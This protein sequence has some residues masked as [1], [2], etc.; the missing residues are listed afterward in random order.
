MS[1]GYVGGLDREYPPVHFPVRVP[2]PKRIALLHSPG[3]RVRPQGSCSLAFY[4]SAF[5]LWNTFQSRGPVRMEA[6]H[7]LADE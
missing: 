5:L 1:H 4:S 7:R 6:T 2:Q 3:H